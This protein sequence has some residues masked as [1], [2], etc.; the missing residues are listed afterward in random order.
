MVQGDIVQPHKAP[1]DAYLYVLEGM[2]TVEIEG[3][4]VQ[5]APD[6]CPRSGDRQPGGYFRL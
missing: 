1:V 5:A 6:V 2:A 3:E 4:S